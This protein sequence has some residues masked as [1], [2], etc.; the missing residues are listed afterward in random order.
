MHNR[1]KKRALGWR[2]LLYSRDALGMV[3]LVKQRVPLVERHEEASTVV[4]A[5]NIAGL[6]AIMCAA[7]LSSRQAL[8]G[9]VA[10]K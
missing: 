4:M 10:D 5:S 2:C 3:G 8:G 9:P 7:K 6:S 1:N